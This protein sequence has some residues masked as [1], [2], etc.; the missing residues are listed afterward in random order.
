MWQGKCRQGMHT[1]FEIRNILKEVHVEDREGD[2]MITSW[3][4]GL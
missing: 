4:D 3:I 1:D 2:L